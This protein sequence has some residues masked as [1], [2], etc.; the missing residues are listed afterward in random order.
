[1]VDN[2]NI[3]SKL[4]DKLLSNKGEVNTSEIKKSKII[5]LYFSAHWC[6]PC[7]GF[8][9]V[10]ATC[11]DEWKKDNKSIEII[12]IS[13]DKNEEEFKNYFKEM[14]WLAIPKNNTDAIN[15]IKTH[16]NVRGIP[17][18]IVLDSNGKVIDSDARNEVASKNVEAIKKWE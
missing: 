1:M 18:F 14:P 10:L 7:R 3:L 16:F 2:S 8:T 12:F 15:S 6:P 4:P 11:Y 13:S 17:T 5:G 9:P